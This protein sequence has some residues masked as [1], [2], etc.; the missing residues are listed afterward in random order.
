MSSN[1]NVLLRLYLSVI[2]PERIGYCCPPAARLCS[3]HQ[4]RNQSI[5]KSLGGRTRGRGRITSSGTGP[6]ARAGR[7]A[8]CNPVTSFG[9]QRGVASNPVYCERQKILACFQFRG[10]GRPVCRGAHVVKPFGSCSL[11]GWSPA[12]LRATGGASAMHGVLRWHSFLLLP[13]PGSLPALFF[14]PPVRRHLRHGL[15]STRTSTP[16]SESA[17]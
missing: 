13:R 15:D 11:R 4:S 16:D 1:T 9:S 17:A 5:G 6:G 10:E 8:G 3:S 7:R 12:V 2:H 14:W